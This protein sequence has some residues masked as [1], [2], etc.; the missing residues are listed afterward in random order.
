MSIV[1]D[2]GFGTVSSSL[3][4]VPA[5]GSEKRIQW[6]YADGRPGEALFEPVRA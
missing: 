4:A 6:L 1:T 3:I 2:S 5:P